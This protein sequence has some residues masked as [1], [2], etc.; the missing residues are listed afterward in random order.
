LR[1]LGSRLKKCR[2]WFGSK[3][4]DFD[5]KISDVVG[6]Y[7]DPAKDAVVLSLDEKP[8]I[9]SLERSTGYAKT[10]SGKTALGHGS[11]YARH[12]ALNLFTALNVRTGTVETLL[13]ERKRRIEF[14]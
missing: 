4:P 13:T 6:L 3:D 7:M 10:S 14:L 11:T 9:Q 12:G 2:S 8:G 1:K 5:K